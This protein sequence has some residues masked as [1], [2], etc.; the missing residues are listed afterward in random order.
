[1]CPGTARIN[2]WIDRGRNAL[3]KR[4]AGVIGGPQGA[5][6]A[7]LVTGKR[8]L[9]PEEA[10]DV[11]RAAG[12]YHVVSISGLHM[13]LAAG[14][15]LWSMR[16]LLALFPAIA[17]T[18]PIK[19]W[20]AAFAICGAI[21]YDIFAGSEVATERSLVMT[22]VMLGAVAC[23]AARLLHAQSRHR[24]ADRAGARTRD[25]ARAEFPDVLCGGGCDDRRLRASRR[26]AQRGP[27]PAAGLAWRSRAH[28]RRDGP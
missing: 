21:A 26:F 6:A 9:I 1:M 4:I 15:F 16:A 18:K 7:A 12:I 8:G 10:N 28:L 14:L 27:C 23:R 20:A 11:L 13:V 5:V 2:A 25:L 24:G 22:L 19:A 17:L 3:T